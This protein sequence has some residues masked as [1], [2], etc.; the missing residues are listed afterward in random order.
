M[1]RE[2]FL[3]RFL[4]QPAPTI[5][6]PKLHRMQ[7]A[8]VLIPLLEVDQELH[9]LLTQRSARLRHHAGQIS[10]PGG[11]QESS[12]VNL[13]ETALRE[14]HEEIG[15]P[16]DD[17]SL[18]GQLHDYPVISN[19]IVRPFVAFI[20]PKQP[21]TLDQH[22]VAD[23]FTVPLAQ[24]LQQRQHYVYRLRRLLYDQVYFMPYQQ[25]NIWGATAGMLRE[26]ADHVYPER[27]RLYRP[28]N[29]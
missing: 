21:F 22:E 15:L 3:Q 5:Q 24:I 14:T 11:R 12:D 1:T 28:L 17:V 26:L 10:F 13:M 18:I 19:F 8:A 6:R 7:P 25:R 2:E 20:D 23:I 9:V 27:Q 16:P 4:L 29:D